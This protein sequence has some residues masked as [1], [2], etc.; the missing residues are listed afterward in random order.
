[1]HADAHAVAHVTACEFCC[2]YFSVAYFCTTAEFIYRGLILWGT[3][4]RDHE[5][6]ENFYGEEGQQ[7]ELTQSLILRPDFI[8]SS[9]LHLTRDIPATVW[10]FSSSILSLA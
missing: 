5:Y 4:A 1:M 9:W 8:R 10:S 3:G 2:I 6:R 7:G